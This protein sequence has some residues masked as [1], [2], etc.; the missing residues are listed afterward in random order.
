MTSKEILSHRNHSLTLP[1][2]VDR[3]EIISRS[4]KFDS[5]DL[6]KDYDDED[7]GCQCKLIIDPGE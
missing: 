3:F 4:V 6:I 1:P 2:T 7:N 5:D